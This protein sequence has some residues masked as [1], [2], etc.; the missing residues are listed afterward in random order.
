MAKRPANEITA[1]AQHAGESAAEWV[2]TAS[3]VPW[4]RNPRKNDENVARVAKSIQRFG[5]ASPIIARTAD[6]TIIAGH[7]R[8]KAAQSL[9]LDRV[10]VRFLDL[11]P[12]DAQ[13]LALADNRL[14]ELSPWDDGEL[15]RILSEHSLADAALAGWSSDDLEQMA[16]E[17]IGK[18][19]TASDADA[20]P[21]IDRAAELMRQWG[22]ALGQSWSLGKHRLICAD[23]TKADYAPNAEALFFDPP[24]DAGIVMPKRASTLAFCD[25]QRIADVVGSFGPPAWAFS[26]DCVTSWYTPNRPLK[27][28]K[29]CLWYGD[30]TRYNGNG[31]HYGDAGEARVVSN[32]RGLYDFTP[33]PRGKHLSDVFSAPITRLH[34][35]GDHAHEKPIDWIRMLIA[36]CTS[37]DVYDPFA[38]SGAA[39]MACEQL[40]RRCVS[41]ELSPAYCAV[42]LQR[43]QDA[44]GVVPVLDA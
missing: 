10:P 21:Q 41:V 35:E 31:S 32:S 29:M 24:W 14:N 30:V 16:S 3:L 37:G 15:Q 7:T 43:Y 17:L 5:F 19:A 4:D 34:S 6:R 22:T 9:G 1:N 25:G 42:I 40:G 33:D 20:E 23:S 11:D 8:W 26:W 38:G 18:S 27:R 36:N 44:I 12:A 28:M 13:L 2:A 39:L